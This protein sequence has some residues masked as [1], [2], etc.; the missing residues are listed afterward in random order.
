[1]G[2]LILIVALGLIGVSLLL[3]IVHAIIRKAATG[4]LAVLYAT[5]LMLI[6][7]YM[8]N[9][10]T[11]SGVAFLF[12]LLLTGFVAFIP[13]RQPGTETFPMHWVSGGLFTVMLTAIL[14]SWSGLA[15]THFLVITPVLLLI[16]CLI[17]YLMT[18]SKRRRNPVKMIQM[19]WIMASTTGVGFLFQAFFIYRSNEK[20]SAMMK[21]VG[22]PP[23]VTPE[24]T[25]AID[26]AM[27]IHNPGWIHILGI[28]LIQVPVLLLLSYWM[29]SS[30][31]WKDPAADPQQ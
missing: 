10:N 6:L 5:L 28:G 30:G 21:A 18:V 1:M 8:S 26:E 19:A 11:F 7:F 23:P 16:Q 14:L 15:G 4:I 12:P 22:D 3:I 17:Y 13:L 29:K 24:I 9:Y 2:Y 25:V 20:Y 27:G 31:F